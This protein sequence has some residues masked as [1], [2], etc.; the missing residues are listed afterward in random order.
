MQCTKI[1]HAQWTPEDS[2]WLRDILSGRKELHLRLDAKEAIDSFRGLRS[3]ISKDFS[4]YLK[5]AEEE[6]DSFPFFV[7]A[8]VF[9]MQGLDE[10]FPIDR[11]SKVAF[12]QIKEKAVHPS[13]LSFDD[14]LR[15]LFIPSERAKA[16]NRRKA[17]AWKYY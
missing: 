15:Q 5:P 1:L 4:E 3:F 9:L 11:I 13:G 6:K 10:E 14:A 7:P 8:S 12:P 2:V 16:R 17:N